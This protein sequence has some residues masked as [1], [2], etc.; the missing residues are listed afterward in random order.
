MRNVTLILLVLIVACSTPAE[1]ILLPYQQ[2]DF[3]SVTDGKQTD[4][5]TLQN[6]QGMLVTLTNLGA[7][8]VSIYVPDRAGKFDDVMMGFNSIAD[9]MQYNATH[10]ATIGPFA[11]RIGGASFT[12]DGEAWQLEKNNGGN[13]LHSGFNT[14]SRRIWDAEQKG[15]SW[16][17]RLPKASRIS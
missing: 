5:Y 4:L 6:D 12:I 3:Q 2:E 11:N 1:K 15:N 17:S 8:I 7:K 9:Y 14:W 10:G 16:N 13:T